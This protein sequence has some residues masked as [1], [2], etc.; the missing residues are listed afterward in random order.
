[1]SFRYLP[2]LCQKVADCDIFFQIPVKIPYKLRFRAKMRGD[3][4]S[5]ITN[6]SSPKGMYVTRYHSIGPFDPP[7]NRSISF[8][9]VKSKLYSSFK[10]VPLDNVP[11]KRSRG[12][13]P[14]GS[15]SLSTNFFAI[16]YVNDGDFKNAMNCL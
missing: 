1:M 13:V 3:D 9:S 10:S 8:S 11:N 6:T 4:F 5:W 12:S 14:A 7:I 15:L 16:S 2:I